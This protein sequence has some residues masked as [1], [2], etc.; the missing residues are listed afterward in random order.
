MRYHF[1]IS[2]SAIHLLLLVGCLPFSL[3]AQTTDTLST[4]NI[5]SA[6]YK[7]EPGILEFS[8]TFV[9]PTDSV[10][11]LDCLV[12]P[13][14]IQEGKNLVLTLD[15][16][17]GPGGTSENMDAF[18]PQRIGPHQTFQGTRRFDHILGEATLRPN[19]STVQLAIVYYPERNE[20]E[21]VP[22][23]VERA[24]RVQ[25]KKHSAIR[26]GKVPLPPKKVKIAHP[27]DP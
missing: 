15:R 2:R 18:L 19:F 9:N 14:F 7:L 21:G 24:S 10:V 20:G 17:S 11:F 4:L 23:L 3:F 5:A 8:F 27:V 1:S 25:S 13:K 6:V 16:T 26:L 22:F 12:P